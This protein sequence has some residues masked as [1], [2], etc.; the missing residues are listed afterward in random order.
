M[1]K[2]YGNEVESVQT[3]GNTSNF[4]KFTVNRAGKAIIAFEMQQLFACCGTALIANGEPLKRYSDKDDAQAVF[5]V[6]KDLMKSHFSTR[7]A[8]YADIEGGVLNAVLSHG[9]TCMSKYRNPNS[10][11][12]VELRSFTEDPAVFDKSD[13]Y[14][15]DDWVDT[16]E[17]YYGDGYDY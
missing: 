1:R 3:K 5:T 6:V 10:D 2:T 11:N 12:I 14:D 13:D 15:S 16:S 4:T 7:N 8:I 17:D 9:F